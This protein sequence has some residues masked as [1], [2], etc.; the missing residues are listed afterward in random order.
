MKARTLV[1][2]FLS[3][4]I[5]G[6]LPGALLHPQRLMGASGRAATGQLPLGMSLIGQSGGQ[7]TAVAVQGNYAYV[8]VGLRLITLNIANPSNPLM[9][10]QSDMLP[11]RIISLAVA[12]NRVYAALG[13]SG[14]RIID[15]ST[16]A[17]PRVVGVLSTPGYTEDV[18]VQGNY[19]YII[20]GLLRIVDVSNPAN[21]IVVS[22]YRTEYASVAVAVAGNY[23]YLPTADPEQGT[24]VLNVSDPVRP[25]AVSIIPTSDFSVDVV[26][27]GSYAFIFSDVTLQIVNITD[28]AAPIEVNAMDT[29]TFV[30]KAVISGNYIYTVG[31]DMNII[32]VADPANPQVAATITAY[33]SED[34]AVVG[35][36]AYMAAGNEG[37]SVF[38]VSPP[39]GAH[40]ANDIVLGGDTTDIALAGNYA[41][42]AARN[43]GMR[44]LDVR[45][46]A[47]PLEVDAITPI[48]STD[49]LAV[50]GHHA[51][52]AAGYSGMHIVDILRPTN[53]ALVSTFSAENDVQ[54]VEV[55]SGYA[56]L[57]DG[58]NGLTVVDVS[59]PANPELVGQTIDMTNGRKVALAGQYAYVLNGYPYGSNGDPQLT[60]VDIADPYNPTVTTAITMTEGLDLEVSGEYMYVAA[61]SFGLKILDISDPIHPTEIGAYDTLG[62]ATGLSII[63]KNIYLADDNGGVRIID[64]TNPH[65]PVEIGRHNPL[66]NA[67]N[68]AV[69]ANKVFVA[70]GRDGLA[71]LQ[72]YDSS[73]PPTP[74]ATTAPPTAT[75]TREP[76]NQKHSYLP[77]VVSSKLEQITPSPTIPPPQTAKVCDNYEPNDDRRLSNKP[78]P[79]V[80]GQL[81]QAKLCAGDT[82]DNF[83]FDTSTNQAVVF[84]LTLP[85]SLVNFVDIWVYA[86]ADFDPADPQTKWSP[87]KNCGTG[88]VRVATYTSPACTIPGAGR[89]IVRLYSYGG[90]TNDTTP[91]TL[92]VRYT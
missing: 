33:S 83:F 9:V 7:T 48:G 21:P 84:T 82:E 47:K 91:Y 35:D 55:R 70:N 71:V 40:I 59:D 62:A 6:S 13:V 4:A 31:E 24:V 27:A 51:Y 43:A 2:L 14:L 64:V 19:A 34:I 89:Y 8:G 25:R 92:Q 77:V 11:D 45:N 66:W 69:A 65:S 44:V 68:V 37:L 87:V 50:A 36:F 76:P 67:R 22:S 53:V 41:F 30:A 85:N 29:P 42:V 81:Y 61:G 23:V 78:G 28:P 75:P 10:G 79:L 39:S 3:V 26:V 1:M 12:N 72:V 60:V 63:G 80:S 5:L 15:V 46:P 17:A 20:D 56:Y 38:D 57:A 58:E 32:N 73:S 49:S 88:P 52:L 90:H 86:Q 54:D 18:A 16:P 74:T